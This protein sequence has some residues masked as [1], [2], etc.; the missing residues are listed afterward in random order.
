MQV[1]DQVMSATAEVLTGEARTQA[2]GQ[3]IAIAPSYA[4]Y[5][6]RTTREIPLVLLRPDK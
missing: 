6:K 2:W 5:T 3:V 1:L 4:R